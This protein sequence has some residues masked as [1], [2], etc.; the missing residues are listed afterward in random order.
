MLVVGPGKEQRKSSSKSSKWPKSVTPVHVCTLGGNI[1]ILFSEALHRD[2]D[3]CR[4]HHVISHAYSI[5]A[6]GQFA[7]GC[8]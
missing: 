5:K 2:T 8:V 6:R 1:G 7:L 3:V 4:S